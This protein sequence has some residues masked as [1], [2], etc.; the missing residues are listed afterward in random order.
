MNEARANR[1]LDCL[2]RTWRKSD[3]HYRSNVYLLPYRDFHGS[4]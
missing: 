3:A 1:I 4:Y 2:K